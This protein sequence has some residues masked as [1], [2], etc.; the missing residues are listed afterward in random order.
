MPTRVDVAIIGAGSAGLSALGEVRKVTNDFIV[1]DDGPLGTTC[2]CVGCMPS[3]ALIQVA[4]EYHHALHLKGRGIHGG[5]KLRLMI[6]EALVWVRKLRDRFRAGPV[7]A[8]K[9]LGSRLVRG[10]ALFVGPNRLRVGKKEYHARRV[11]LATGSRPVMPEEFL[12]FGD[13]VITTDALFERKDLPAR[14]G[15]IGMGS[16]GLEIGQAL[17]RLGCDVIAF[18]RSSGLGKLTD[19]AVN[20]YACSHFAKEFPIHF[21]SEVRLESRSGK[22]EVRVGG[23]SYERDLILASL[24]RR[25]NLDSLGLEA[26]GVELNAE[27]LPKFNAGTMKLHGQPIYLAGDASARR[28]V[29]HEASDDG[30]I[31]GYNGVRRSQRVFNRRAPLAITFSEPNLALVGKS[32][33]ELKRGRFVT[34]E[35]SFELDGRSLILGENY[36]LLHVYARAADGRFLGA[37][38]V[39]PE[40]EHLAHLMAWA[41]QQKLTIF[42]MLKM[43][44]YHPVVEEG[45]RAA[46]RDAAR[47]VKNRLGITTFR[48]PHFSE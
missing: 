6:P 48:S 26:A 5:N 21:N 3:K 43:P 35:A 11:I 46:L 10:R 30:R 1:I 41:L 39:G 7:F 13:K 15:V 44:F 8:A 27:G 42:E 14:I 4:N 40:G 38:M 31:A 9:R 28:P 18:D 19:P 47:K 16:I 36:G 45:L 25:P 20:A 37:E 2:A 22:I 23:R 34:G 12:A 32:R 24:G 17:A 29:L 33:A